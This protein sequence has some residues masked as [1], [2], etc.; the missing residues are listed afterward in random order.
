MKLLEQCQ[1]NW[2]GDESVHLLAVLLGQSRGVL[3]DEIVGGMLGQLAGGQVGSLVGSLA[4]T[5]KRGIGWSVCSSMKLSEQC[6]DNW[7]GDWS[8]AGMIAGIRS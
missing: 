7:L 2:Q 6:R 1:D 5:I 3:V 4:G 8:V